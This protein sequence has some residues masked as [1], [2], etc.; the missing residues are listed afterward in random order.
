M[1]IGAILQNAQSGLAVSQAAIGVISQNVA[2]AN[3][4]GY[5]RQIAELQE[6][7]VGG[8]GSG[9]EIAGIKRVVDTFLVR[10][11]RGQASAL[12]K[13]DERA[14]FFKEIEARFGTPQTNS[15]V[16][17]ALANLSAALNTL[18]TAPENPAL[19]FKVT[20]D[21][22]TVADAVKSLATGVQNL[23]REA[24]QEIDSAVTELNTQLKVIDQINGKISN[25]LTLGQSTAEFEDSR[26][27]AV[28]KIARILDITTF[29]RSNGELSILTGGGQTLLDTQLHEVDFAPAATLT[30]GTVFGP[31]TIFAID[32]TTG[33]RTGSGKQ[34]VSGG[35]SGTVTSTVT[36]GR[37][38]GLLNIRDKVLPDLGNQMDTLATAVR[39]TYNATH[40]QG[41]TF[42]PP[43]RLTG[44]RTVASTDA[45]TATGSFRV[46][47]VDSTGRI[48]G[49]PFDSLDLSTFA[50]VG[51]L[52][53][54]I[55]TALG[56]DGTASV[57][58]GKLEIRALNAANGVAVNERDSKETATGRGLAHYFGLNDFFSGTGST[59]FAVRSDIVA[60]P[61]LVATGFLS[62]ADI[63]QSKVVTSRTATLDSASSL[64]V[65]TDGTFTINGTDPA[66]TIAF[67][68]AT[69]TLDS[70]AAKIN[71]A[72]ITG[73]TASVAT[74]T[75]GF[76]L[77]IDSTAAPLDIRSASG[78]D[79]VTAAAFQPNLAGQTGVTIGDNRAVQQLANLTEN[80]VSF[81]AVGGL[82][83]GDFTFG[84]YAGSILGLDSVLAADATDTQK[85]NQDLFDNLNFRVSSV[86][87]VNVDEELASMVVFQNAFAASA[88]VITTGVAMFDELLKLV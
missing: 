7:V 35:T 59:D 65:A 86:A 26:D 21:A 11:L 50:T 13:A 29:A 57:V 79:I 41:T 80:R 42:P 74:D 83:A 38:A 37:L 54:A 6:R 12:G 68:A 67:T 58:N 88:R 34:I 47:V 60:D 45:L 18:A 48:V 32:G 43:T 78:G 27:R 1:T 31:L 19:R 40:N 30:S 72:G 9:V 49:T 84:E 4:V 66:N 71:A 77:V 76:R 56:S 53:T 46:A 14:N 52:A 24:D 10:E 8:V 25:A 28:A 15:T 23:R 75:G 33:L 70:L 73:V 17:G 36:S 61:S 64:N 16:T 87:G 5:S 22:V 51:D 44:T 62:L 55:D 69:D 2:N 85:L 82:P 81:T 63:Q 39:D 20:A 3:T